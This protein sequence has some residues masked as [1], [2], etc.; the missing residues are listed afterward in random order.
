[1]CQPAGI[2]PAT[3]YSDSSLPTMNHDELSPQNYQEPD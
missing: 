3:Y 1:M 2:E